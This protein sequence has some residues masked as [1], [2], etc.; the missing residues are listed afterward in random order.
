MVAPRHRKLAAIVLGLALAGIPAAAVHVWLSNYIERQAAGELD[1]VAKRV[2]ALAETR[3]GAAIEAL[4]DLTNRGVR[5]CAGS[6]LAA[7]N[8]TSFSVTPVKEVSAVAPDGATLCTNLAVPLGERK[9]VSPPIASPY[10]GVII[11]VLR[12]GDRADHVVRV[13]NTNGPDGAGLA[14]LI[15]ADLFLP[16][17][18]SNGGPNRP[19]ARIDTID[20]TLVGERARVCE[21]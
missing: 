20:G 16:R 15:P 13:R 9:V 6:D 14:V 8:E 4:D 17:T 21:P 12:I 1:V 19:R 7:M 18:S 3:L 2:I 10:P 5:S 11:E